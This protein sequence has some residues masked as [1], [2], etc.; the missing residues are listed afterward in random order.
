MNRNFERR[1]LSRYNP[2]KIPNNIRG[3]FAG[4]DIK[5]PI[6]RLLIYIVIGLIGFLGY[7]SHQSLKQLEFYHVPTISEKIEILKS[8]RDRLCSSPKKNSIRIDRNAN[9]PGDG[10]NIRS[11]ISLNST[12]LA[13]DYVIN[14]LGESS[15]VIMPYIGILEYLELHSNSEQKTHTNNSESE[16]HEKTSP[17]PSLPEFSLGKLIM[18]EFEKI[19]QVVYT[20]FREEV[21]SEN[22]LIYILAIS[23]R[24]QH[25]LFMIL[26]SKARLT[27]KVNE[28]IKNQLGRLD[29]FLN[30]QLDKI[31]FPQLFN[32]RSIVDEINRLR[33]LITQIK[34]AIQLPMLYLKAG[35]MHGAYQGLV[36]FASPRFSSIFLHH[37]NSFYDKNDYPNP[38]HYFSIIGEKPVDKVWQSNL[39]KLSRF[40]SIYN[41]S[42]Y[43]AINESLANSVVSNSVNYSTSNRSK[44]LNEPVVSVVEQINGYGEFF[45]AI[46][47]ARLRE[48]YEVLEFLYFF[49]KN[50]VDDPTNIQ[51]YTE[52]MEGFNSPFSQDRT[53]NI[54]QQLRRILPKLPRGRNR[55]NKFIHG[56][57]DW[58]SILKAF[59]L[60]G[61]KKMDDQIKKWLLANVEF[62]T[63]IKIST[64]I[65]ENPI[66]YQYIAKKQTE[67]LSESEKFSMQQFEERIISQDIVGKESLIHQQELTQSVDEQKKKSAEIGAKLNEVFK[68]KDSVG[69]FTE[70]E[71][72]ILHSLDLIG[73]LYELR[74]NLRW[75][76]HSCDAINISRQIN[77]VVEDWVHR[78]KTK[79]T[80]YQQDESWQ[81]NPF[82]GFQESGTVYQTYLESNVRLMTAYKNRIQQ[83]IIIHKENSSRLGFFSIEAQNQLIDEVLGLEYSLMNRLKSLYMLTNFWASEMELELNAREKA[84]E[85]IA[86]NPKTII[87]A[88]ILSKELLTEANSRLSAL[89]EVI[90]RNIESGAIVNQYSSLTSQH[91]TSLTPTLMNPKFLE[92]LSYVRYQHDLQK[93][94]QTF[95][96]IKY[97]SSRSHR[98]LNQF[99][100]L[101]INASQSDFVTRHSTSQV[102]FFWEEIQRLNPALPVLIKIQEYHKERLILQN[103]FNNPEYT[104]QNMQIS[105]WDRTDRI[106]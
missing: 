44:I 74:R 95:P 76:H 14:P 103:T 22:L 65:F 56:E 77:V 1:H 101:D 51:N 55:T 91:W 39:N 61:G 27:T 3:S 52:K 30:R 7:Q 96:V 64:R 50:L 66:D 88:G 84:I 86:R 106:F 81:S 42:V 72:K 71:I 25:F 31:N 33:T 46:N 102:L 79:S 49:A 12:N 57:T 59:Y 18:D 23:H 62:A 40:N 73:N 67:E 29:D 47:I 16:H 21:Y 90:I 43:C 32:T 10:L 60:L 97:F 13:C 6:L 93:T 53:Q 48:N 11:Q 37:P 82:P 80:D 15:K 83:A 87:I 17:K 75:I 4:V 35:S 98:V 41:S 8:D 34:L 69:N 100:W 19:S 105:S 20:F 70:L 9:S 94:T 24:L 2:N 54:T 68:M 89:R 38:V 58:I 78:L 63:R 36:D 104:D 92:Y 99:Q 28:I 26:V 45:G 5:P 85:A